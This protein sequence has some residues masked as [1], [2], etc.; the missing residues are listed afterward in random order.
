M[1]DS[2]RL[3]VLGA[4]NIARKVVIPSI[5]HADGVELVAIGSESARATEFLRET[6]LVTRDGRQLAET[7]RACTY[8]E[9]IA[10]DD[11]DAVYIALPNQLH[12][13]W[14]MRAAD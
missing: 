3:G 1:S 4:A 12:A 7:A 13:P 2:V 6:D 5:L 8:D 14:S 11:V 10:A 9:L